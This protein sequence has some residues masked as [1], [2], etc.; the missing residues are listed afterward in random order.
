MRILIASSY[1]DDP[2]TR[3][4]YRAAAGFD[5]DLLVAS[6]AGTASGEG[7]VR[8]APVVTR[9]APT[10]GE[11]LRWHGPTLKRLLAEHRPDVVHIEADPETHLASLVAQ[12]AHKAGVPYS[13]FSWRSLPAQLGFWAGRRARAVLRGASGVI[14]GNRLAMELLVNQARDA[15][16]TIIPQVGAPLPDARPALTRETLTI[17][18]AGR[19]VPERGADFLI[20]ALGQ[21]FGTWR[22]IVAGTGP[23]QENLEASVARLGLASRIEWLGGLRREALDQLWSEI[24]CLVVPSRDTPSWVEYHSP[25]LLEAM[26]HGI[27]PVVTRAGCLPDLV[28]DAGVVVD[29]E[30]RLTETLQ[31]W[32]VNPAGCRARGLEAR[33]RLLDRYVTNAVAAQTVAFWR[34]V[35]RH[36]GAPAIRP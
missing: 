18:F 3:D 30:E 14:G 8:Y 26:G 35:Q 11:G 6:P 19:L 23:E 13:L 15:I 4:K 29:S 7:P 21:T 27:T 31:Q 1:L 12:L 34:E 28:G 24:D 33:Q 10:E 20:G 2:S 36:A 9:G 16:A 25:V 5:A 32:V 22:L 17:G